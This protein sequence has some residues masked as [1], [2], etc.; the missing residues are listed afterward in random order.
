LKTKL[1]K[2]IEFLV[3]DSPEQA[4]SEKYFRGLVRL[5]HQ[6]PDKKEAANALI[7]KLSK[8]SNCSELTTSAIKFL[9]LSMKL[10]MYCP[11]LLD[12]SDKQLPVFKQLYDHW[13]NIIQK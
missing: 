13:D 7:D 2:V 5:L 10:S 4:F 12:S 9:G 3:N 11:W 6:H 8:V 1:D